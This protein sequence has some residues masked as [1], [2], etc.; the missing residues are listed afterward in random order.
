MKMK[1]KHK[2]L[3][4]IISGPSGAGKGTICKAYMDEVQDTWLSVSATTRSPRL[5]EEDGKHYFFLSKEDFE[6]KISEGNFLEYAQVYGN[7]YGT[8]LDCVQ[9]KLESG[10]DV[11]LEI[12]IQGALRVKQSYEDGIF[13]FILPPSLEE[14]K[15]RLTNRGSETPESLIRRYE[16]A[17]SEIN[18]ISEYNYAVINTTV[19]EAKE[20]VKAIILAE[21]CKVHRLKQDVLKIREEV[22]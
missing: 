15:N 7:Y 22:K 3:L 12:D 10:I 19:E 21:K 14:L 20:K 1:M 17:I 4:F 11:I 5:G 18:Y 13:I 16:S 9:E 2:G 8:P 6:Q